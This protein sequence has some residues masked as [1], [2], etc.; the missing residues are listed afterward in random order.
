MTPKNQTVFR[1][2]LRH[3]ADCRAT[4]QN[5]TLLQTRAAS[6]LSKEENLAFDAAKF[7]VATNDVRNRINHEKLAFFSPVIKI[8]QC[9]DG[10]QFSDENALDEECVNDAG[11]N[12]YAVGAEV[13]LSVSH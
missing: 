1:D 13:V 11:S 7:I 4:E 12:I 6:A 9:D 3:V 8:E 5:W 10:L 2:L